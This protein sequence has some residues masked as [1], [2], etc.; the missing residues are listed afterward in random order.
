MAG[1]KEFLTLEEVAQRLD[2][3]YQTIY[4][5]ARS[6]QLPAIRVGRVYRV[7]NRDFEAYLEERSTG[8]QRALACGTCGRT[9]LGPEQIKHRTPTGDPICYDCWMRLGRGGEA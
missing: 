8:A 2:V 7:R 6:G 5:L 1:D 3:S 9:G 4:R